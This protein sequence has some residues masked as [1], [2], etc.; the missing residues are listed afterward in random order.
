MKKT[1]S[2][3][4]RDTVPLSELSS[5][6]G[7]MVVGGGGGGWRYSARPLRFLQQA[8]G[9]IKDDVNGFSSSSEICFMGIGNY[10]G[11]A[12]FLELL[13]FFFS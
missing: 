3:K 1:R 5:Q 4:S 10:N 13:Y 2:K 9:Q 12:L 11:R 8:S 7:N 6:L